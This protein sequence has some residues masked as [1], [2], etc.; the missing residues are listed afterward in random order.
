MS[1]FKIVE[2][3]VNKEIGNMSGVI[4]DIVLKIVEEKEKQFKNEFPL[5]E[6]IE[7]ESYQ[8]CSKTSKMPT[9]IRMSIKMYEDLVRAAS[10]NQVGSVMPNSIRGMEIVIDDK[11]EDFDLVC[12]ENFISVAWQEHP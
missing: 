5:I 1:E 4:N 3:N 10:F 8:F 6:K 7:V 9:E 11:L 12:Y 2:N